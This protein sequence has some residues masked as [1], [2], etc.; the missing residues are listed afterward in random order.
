MFTGECVL[1]PYP[2][3]ENKKGRGVGVAS[4]VNKIDEVNS[5]LIAA[6]QRPTDPRLIIF[7]LHKKTLEK[8]NPSSAFNREVCEDASCFHLKMSGWIYT[9]FGEAAKI[10]K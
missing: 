10:V 9:H 6:S 2:H 1:T 3:T 5:A 4:E 7:C 8:F